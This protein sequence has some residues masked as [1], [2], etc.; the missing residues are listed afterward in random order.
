M[1]EIIKNYI[2]D[3]LQDR[4]MHQSA[5]MFPEDDCTCI[6]P[7]DIEYDT[8]LLRGGYIDSFMVETI[9][10]FMAVEFDVDIPDNE[11]VEN[12]FDTIDK[13]VELIKSHK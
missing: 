11:V 12:N 8:S 10:V 7:D 6:R 3:M 9:V 13:M 4:N 5:C 2:L 1:K